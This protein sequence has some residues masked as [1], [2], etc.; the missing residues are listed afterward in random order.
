MPGEAARRKATNS[1]SRAARALGPKTLSVWGLDSLTLHVGEWS[2]FWAQTGLLYSQATNPPKTK[3]ERPQGGAERREGGRQ[4]MGQ[5][6]R[7]KGWFTWHSK[8][9]VPGIVCARPLNYK[10]LLA[11]S[12]SPFLLPSPQPLT[13]SLSLTL[14]FTLFCL[15]LFLSVWA[16]WKGICVT[17]SGHQFKLTTHALSQKQK[18]SLIKQKGA[19]ERS[20]LSNQKITLYWQVEQVQIQRKIS[21]L[22]TLLSVLEVCTTKACEIIWDW[23]QMISQGQLCGEN[24][25]AVVTALSITV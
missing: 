19:G 7:A 10:C 9:C 1:D 23:G 17:G 4:W 5:K 11:F 6:G 15:P 20:S 3:A 24:L 2:S 21:I 25:R 18:H 16:E 14:T 8:S 12:L 22:K 13:H